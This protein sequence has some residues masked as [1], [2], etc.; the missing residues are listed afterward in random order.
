MSHTAHDNARLLTRTRRL[1]GQVAALERALS[2]TVECRDVLTQIAA[3][4]GAAQGLMMEVLDGHLREHIADEKRAAVRH[5][6]VDSV[7]AIL[8]SYFK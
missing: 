4:R 5:E 7:V 1:K 2:E 8:R 6:E 3:I